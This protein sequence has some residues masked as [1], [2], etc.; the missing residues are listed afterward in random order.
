MFDTQTRR[1]PRFARNDMGYDYKQTK[2]LIAAFLMLSKIKSY[3]STISLLGL[4]TSGTS[5]LK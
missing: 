2:K 5:C 4:F 1:L 3:S